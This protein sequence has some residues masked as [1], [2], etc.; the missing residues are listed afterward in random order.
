MRV[1]DNVKCIMQVV[2]LFKDPVTSTFQVNNSL[3]EGDFH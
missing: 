3:V 1:K 2:S